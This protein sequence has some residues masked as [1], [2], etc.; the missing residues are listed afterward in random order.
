[1][2]LI[3]KISSFGSNPQELVHLWKTFCLS[4]LEQSC[5][6]WGGMITAENRKDLEQ[7]QK[8]FTKLVLQENY[9]TYKSA[10]VSLDLESLEKRR[11]KLPLRFA[12]TSIADGHFKGLILKKNHKKGPNTR[13]QEH[14]QVTRAYTERFRNSP[15]V[16]M[17]RLLN[18]DRRDT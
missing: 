12:K 7:T 8:S 5:A 1:M 10:L 15:I 2:E 9:T 16:N 11:Q 3:R 18:I 13:H 4:I 14:Y 17:Q 6:V